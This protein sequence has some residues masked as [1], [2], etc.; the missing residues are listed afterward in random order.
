[1][2]HTRL[3]HAVATP[4]AAVTNG[5]ALAAI[6]ASGI[7]AFAVG[8]FVILHETGLFVSPSLYGPAGGL[9]GRTSFAVLTWLAAWG[10]LHARWKRREIA[11]RSVFGATLVLVALGILGTFPP[12]WS[13]F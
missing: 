9:S 3:E 8:L 1:M 4:G 5:A 6:L 2:T 10:L 11:W 13:L 7:G 12:V